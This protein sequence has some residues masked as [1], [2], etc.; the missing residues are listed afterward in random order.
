MRIKYA[1]LVTIFII[2]ANIL[3]FY[4]S[5]K[6]FIS[7]NL[8]L[9]VETTPPQPPAQLKAQKPKDRIQL[10]N[11]HMKKSL[12]I[13]FRDF[14]HFENDL[15]QSIVSIVSLIP[16]IK[17]LVITDE[18][19]YPPMDF[20]LND[21]H[22]GRNISSGD[23]FKNNNVHFM[24][25]RYDVTKSVRDFYPL[26]QIKTRYVLFLPDSVRI[27]GRSVVNRMLREISNN[28]LVDIKIDQQQSL[29]QGDD[30]IVKNL[31]TYNKAANRIIVVPFASNA[32]SVANNCCDINLDFPNWTIEY[33]S[34]NGT[35]DCDMVRM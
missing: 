19:P 25:M 10:A 29:R 3:I 15:K 14:Y 4:Y 16:N 30:K 6:Y 34:K 12:T 13:V 23:I 2:L 21:L 9:E 22:G 18:I 5:W 1:K 26:L 31:F 33:H 24:T 28:D 7:F 32:K 27:N 35:V 8:N 11:K 17:I 20:S